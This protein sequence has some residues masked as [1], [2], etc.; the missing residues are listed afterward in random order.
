MGEIIYFWMLC[1][2]LSDMSELNFQSVNRRIIFNSEKKPIP[3][4]ISLPSVSWYR[5]YVWGEA[6]C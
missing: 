6:V 2:F 1:R 3:E 4:Y 5:I